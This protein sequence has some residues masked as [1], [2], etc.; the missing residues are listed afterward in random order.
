MSLP[1]FWEFPL[2]LQSPEPYPNP[3]LGFLGGIISM[4]CWGERKIPRENV[5]HIDLMSEIDQVDSYPYSLE[6]HM[7]QP[8]P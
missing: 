7:A 2:L 3:F 8:P 5:L 1:N 6:D 4:D